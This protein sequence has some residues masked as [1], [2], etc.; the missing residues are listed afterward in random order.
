MSPRFAQTVFYLSGPMSG[1]PD[2]NYPAFFEAESALF[3]QGYLVANPARTNL[4]EGSPWEAYMR[5][6][7]RKMLGADAV[8]V[9]PGWETSRGARLEVQVAE[10][11]GMPI[12]AY[13]T[14]HRI[15]PGLSE[16]SA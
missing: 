12:F 11:L 13:P 7:L 9:L 14:L 3:S 4:P 2:Y 8:V 16:S 10:A 5:D 15:H 1:L 6:D